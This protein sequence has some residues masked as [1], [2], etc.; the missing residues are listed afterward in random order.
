[1]Q[2][3]LYEFIVRSFLATCS[4]PAVGFE[5]RVEVDIAEELFDAR[6]ALPGTCCIFLGH[7]QV[8]RLPVSSHG[9]GTS[10]CALSAAAA[11]S[12]TRKHAGLMVR[13]RN[14]LDVYPYA[15]WGGRDA[16]PAFQEG[17]TFIP[18]ELL[19]KDVRGLRRA[20]A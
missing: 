15:S 6:G 11:T 9:S 14:W 16:L 18:H 20:E 3:R 17:Q 7:S 12:R 1:M 19:L 10:M 8:L 2:A 13:E 4:K 5:T